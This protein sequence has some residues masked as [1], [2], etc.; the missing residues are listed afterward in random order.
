[1]SLN[2]SNQESITR[3]KQS[4]KEIRAT[5]NI[6]LKDISINY[7]INLIDNKDRVYFEE[8]LIYH[9]LRHKEEYNIIESEDSK[10]IN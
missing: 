10:T 6:F 2:N 5:I 8:D 1:M 3:A 9:I 7:P 4:K